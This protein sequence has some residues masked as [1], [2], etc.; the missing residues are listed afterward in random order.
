ML[1]CQF[2]LTCFASVLL[3]RGTFRGKFHYVDL[4]DYQ[5]IEFG[6]IRIRQFLAE[7]GAFLKKTEAVT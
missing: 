5:K 6:S 7:F 4:V 1:K 2:L 3:Y